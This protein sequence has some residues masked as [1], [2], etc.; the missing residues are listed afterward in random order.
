MMRIMHPRK[1]TRRRRKINQPK[2]WKTT[3]ICLLIP[4]NLK[5]SPRRLKMSL[6]VKI[7]LQRTVISRL[8]WLITLVA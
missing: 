4:K 1:R 6:K 8:R 2:K 3:L 5:K 7:T